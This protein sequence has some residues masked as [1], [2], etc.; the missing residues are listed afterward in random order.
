[1]FR[2]FFF[3]ERDAKEL[4]SRYAERARAKSESTIRA[5]FGRP[6]GNTERQRK[7]ITKQLKI[8]NAYNGD[9][10]YSRLS[11]LRYEIWYI[12]LIADYDVEKYETLRNTKYRDAVN[13]LIEKFKRM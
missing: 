5:E 8:Q 12:P 10:I 9:E 7:Y 3:K 13:N 4:I 1:M 6:D 11:E 2:G